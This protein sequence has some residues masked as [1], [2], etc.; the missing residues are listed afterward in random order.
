M[1]VPC[2]KAL[3]EIPDTEKKRPAEQQIGGTVF[4]GTVTLKPRPEKYCQS[5]DQSPPE[6]LPEQSF[7]DP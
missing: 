1:P 6:Y 2:F 7:H 5:E 3:A 4:S